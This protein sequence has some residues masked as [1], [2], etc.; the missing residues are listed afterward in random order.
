ME[1]IIRA[2]EDMEPTKA[3]TAI[4]PGM[5]TSGEHT[6]NNAD[7]SGSI[8]SA[9]LLLPL[10]LHL[11]PLV[12]RLHR[13]R[14]YRLRLPLTGGGNLRQRYSALLREWPLLFTPQ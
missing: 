14:V 3:S 10:V 11:L 8:G 13:H 12:I 9:K 2:M 6:G 1:G 7:R 4:T 5:A